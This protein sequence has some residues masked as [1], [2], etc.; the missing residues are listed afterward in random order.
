MIFGKLKLWL[1]GLAAL[2]SAIAAVWFGGMR[3]GRRK[4]DRKAIEGRLDAIKTA[5]KL[6]R[7]AKGKTDENLM[8]DISHKPKP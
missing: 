6:E 1:A 8:D 3:A 7:E 4:A 2:L 5:R